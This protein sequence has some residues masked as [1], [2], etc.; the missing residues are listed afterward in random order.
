M[1]AKA[2][3]VDNN[4]KRCFEIL[5]WEPRK[6]VAGFP[7]PRGLQRML[8]CHMIQSLLPQERTNCLGVFKDRRNPAHR[9]RAHWTS[10]QP[11]QRL[12]K[13]YDYAALPGIIVNLRSHM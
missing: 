13:I 11:K 9:P 8:L 7:V 12:S 2:I 6:C 10:Q 3:V 4:K 5:T 1:D